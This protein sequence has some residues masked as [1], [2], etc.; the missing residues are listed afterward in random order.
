MSGLVQIEINKKN[1]W[2]YFTRY[3]WIAHV[4]YWLWVFVAG[5]L[6]TVKVPITPSVIFNH[7]VLENLLIA[8]FYYLYCLILIPYYFKRNRNLLFWMLVVGSYLFFTALDIWFT[9]RFV[10]FY[11]DNP[12]NGNLS[13]WD[14]YSY[15]LGGYLLNFMV[16]SMMLFFME[17]NEEGHTILE[18][19]NEK[20]EIEQ[21]K[22]DL[23]KTNISPD[24]LMRSL[25]QLKQSAVSQDENTPEAILTF[26]DLL[27]YRLYWG[28]QQH[29]PLQEEL[30]A[31]D[32]FIHFI[33]L[34]H[35]K[36]NLDVV[37]N[38]HG[39]VTDQKIAPLSL[40]NILELF[41]KVQTDKAIILEINILIEESQ[42]II[43]MEYHDKAPQTLVADLENYGHNYKQLFGSSVEFDFENCEDSRC[44]I[45]LLLPLQ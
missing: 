35:F 23:L 6:M 12:L 2:V 10:T 1:R 15:S 25:K 11:S 45:S 26:S 44:T 34:N 7:F 27:R 32:N 29:T 9:R 13:F 21:V 42:L 40:I 14:M 17:K 38:V 43:G 28:R 30:Q 33:T 5:T 39:D 16:F 18:L 20:K 4:I 3:R 24:F 22:L 19:E 8:I 31:L 41:C 36:H 37:L